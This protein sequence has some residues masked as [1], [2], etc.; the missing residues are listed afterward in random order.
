MVIPLQSFKTRSWI[1]KASIQLFKGQN[2][3][4]SWQKWGDGA[5]LA[6]IA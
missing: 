5:F 3:T 2:Y 4:L 1:D 6:S